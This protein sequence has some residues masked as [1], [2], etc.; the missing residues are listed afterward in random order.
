MRALV[1]GLFEGPS[2]STYW[3][4]RLETLAERKGR[5]YLH[6]ILTRLDPATASRIAQRDK[7]KLVRALEVRLESGKSLSQHLAEKPRRPLTGFQV[8][9]VGLNPAREELYRRIDDRV[10]RMF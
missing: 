10:I 9:F 5:P 2:R 3:R 1:E 7:P 4:D 8:H 6:R